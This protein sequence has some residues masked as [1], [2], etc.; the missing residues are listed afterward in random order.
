MPVQKCEYNGK[1]GYKYG[2]EGKC[3]VYNHNNPNSEAIAKNNALAQGRA[4]E[5][6]KYNEELTSLILSDD[7]ETNWLDY[8][9]VKNFCWY[10][11]T[12]STT[13]DC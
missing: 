1:P 7:W 10:Y 4:I 11:T 13:I 3:Y 9:S 6:Q 2:N 12:Y 5:S 8:A